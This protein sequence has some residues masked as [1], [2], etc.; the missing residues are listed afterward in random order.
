M[1]LEI[2]KEFLRCDYCGTMHFPDPNSDGVRVLEEPAE[3]SCPLCK[4]P[5]IH[6]AVAGQRMLYCSQCRGMLIP[7]TIFPAMIQDLRAG[8]DTTATTIHLVDLKDL[9]RRIWCPQ[10][11]QQMDTHRYGGPGNIVIDDCERC[12]LNWLDYGELQRIV[13]APDRQYNAQAM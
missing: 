9:D 11:G 5:L 6:A 2:D 10:C 7:M 13:R 1:R 12:S 8:R 4:V 3:L